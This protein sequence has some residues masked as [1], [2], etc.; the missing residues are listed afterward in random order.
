MLPLPRLSFE[1]ADSASNLTQ[2]LLDRFGVFFPLREFLA[3]VGDGWMCLPIMAG[4][5]GISSR[6]R[7]RHRWHNVATKP[8]VGKGSI[9]LDGM[10]N[11]GFFSSK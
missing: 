1:S 5:M 4:I 11:H 8:D 3:G 9:K 2:Q 7:S 6:R 10:H